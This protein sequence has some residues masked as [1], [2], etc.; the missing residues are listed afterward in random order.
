MRTTLKQG[1]SRLMQ[2]LS[3]LHLFTP[4]SRTLGNDLFA[5]A[6]NVRRATR[7]THLRAWRPAWH[8]SKIRLSSAAGSPRRAEIHHGQLLC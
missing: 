1:M 2:R 4:L 3:L 8:C 7:L 5:L 6:T